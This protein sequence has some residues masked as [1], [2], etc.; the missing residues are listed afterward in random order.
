MIQITDQ[1]GHSHRSED[2]SDWLLSCLTLIWPGKMTENTFLFTANDLG[3]SCR[4]RGKGSESVIVYRAHTHAGPEIVIAT[5]QS[6][7]CLASVWVCRAEVRLWGSTLTHLPHL[8]T[9]SANIRLFNKH[10]PLW[11]NALKHMPNCVLPPFLP[12]NLP[13][14]RE[15]EKNKLVPSLDLT[16]ENHP[17]THTQTHK[18]AVKPNLNFLSVRKFILA[19]WWKFPLKA[20]PYGDAWCVCAVESMCVFVHMQRL[21]ILLGYAWAGVWVCICMRE[22]GY[23]RRMPS[24]YNISSTKRFL[25]K[26]M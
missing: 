26:S 17:H 13:P 10:T 9:L 16:A 25:G 7:M 5:S 2:L 4:G 6:D 24:K 8:L 11:C 23:V 19:K 22:I 21:L 14:I 12:T 18:H 20:M 1:E 15:R 3:K